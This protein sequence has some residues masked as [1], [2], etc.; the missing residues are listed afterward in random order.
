MNLDPQWLCVAVGNVLLTCEFHWN[1][2]L[3]HKGLAE[4]LT[5]QK[6]CFSMKESSI[7]R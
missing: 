4:A 1:H 2:V 7:L 6:G 3:E 5:T